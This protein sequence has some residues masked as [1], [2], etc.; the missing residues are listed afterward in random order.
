MLT[1]M[2]DG[3][4]DVSHWHPLPECIANTPSEMQTAG[5]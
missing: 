3:A 1:S 2:H 4:T 5:Y